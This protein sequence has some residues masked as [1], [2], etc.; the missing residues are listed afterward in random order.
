MASNGSERKTICPECGSENLFWRSR[1]EKCGENLHKNESVLPK[2]EKR[3]AGFWIAFFTGLAGALFL[4]LLALIAF[5][6]SGNFPVVFIFILAIPILG[7]A[8]C[9]KSPRIAGAA[10]IIAGILPTVLILAD[11]PVGVIGYLLLL[12]GLSL[13]LTGSGILFIIMGKEQ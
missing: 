5:G 13:P 7:L 10:L 6:F 12:L 1:C 3:G 2:F 11:G 4:C 9:W 8:L